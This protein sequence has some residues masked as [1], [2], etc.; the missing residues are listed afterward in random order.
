MSCDDSHD[1]P[2]IFVIT[3]VKDKSVVTS[4]GNIIQYSY[5]E[6]PRS[7]MIKLNLCQCLYKLN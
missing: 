6:F 2:V 1:F 4:G 5:T 7:K 3:M